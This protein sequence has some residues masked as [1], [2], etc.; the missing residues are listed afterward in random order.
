MNKRNYFVGSGLPCAL[1]ARKR[2][3]SELSMKSAL[4]GRFY[5]SAGG[6]DLE[7]G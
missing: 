4:A 6:S 3:L 2:M 1:R 5:S 7:L